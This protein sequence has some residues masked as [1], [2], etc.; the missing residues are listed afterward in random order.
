MLTI[1]LDHLNSSE[2]PGRAVTDGS[3]ED[4][5]GAEIKGKAAISRLS[6]DDQ[7]GP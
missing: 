2:Q 5:D 6:V 4:L 1:C 3:R 7:T